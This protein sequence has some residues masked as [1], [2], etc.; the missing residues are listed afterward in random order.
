MRQR[1]RRGFRLTSLC[2]HHSDV[3]QSDGLSVQRPSCCDH[4]A[5]A[6][7]VKVAPQ[8]GPPV[9]GIPAEGVQAVRTSGV[10]RVLNSFRRTT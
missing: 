10:S 1:K 3:V 6:V 7:N 5:T 9:Y 8:A 4:T 2:C